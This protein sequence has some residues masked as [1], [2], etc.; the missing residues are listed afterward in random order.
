MQPEMPLKAYEDVKFLKRS[1]MRSVRLQTELLKPQILMDDARVKSTV[2]VF[3]SARTKPLDEIVPVLEA[4]ELRA[5]EHP[6][7]PKALEELRLAQMA[8]RHSRYYEMAREL[9][10]RISEHGQENGELEHVV[11]T[12]GGPGIMEAAN[13]GAHD[14]GLKSIGLNITLPHEQH[15]N[16]YISPDL[17]FL[18]H[19]FSI[20]KM[21]FLLR[22]KALCCFPGGFGTLD[23]L[24]EALTLIQTGKVGRIPVLIF[25]REYWENLVNWQTFVE[26]GTISPEDLELFSYV[27]SVDQALEI[28]TS[29]DATANLP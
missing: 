28:I 7:D 2:V 5:R 22:A 8:E 3:G 12:G 24:F 11:I 19:Y 20:R 26:W 16:P 27:D 17:N 1:E 29:S 13:R 14:V 4:A 9:A 6:H 10:A 25:G 21:H 15:P 18:F 23:E